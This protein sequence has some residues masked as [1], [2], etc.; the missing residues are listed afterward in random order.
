VSVAVQRSKRR[1]ARE[2]TLAQILAAA[3]A[4]LRERPFRELSVDALMAQTGHTRTVF[5]R[6]F[7][8]LADLVLRVLQAAG[9]GRLIEIAEAWAADPADD[10]ASARRALEQIVALFAEHGPLIK[11]VADAASNDEAIDAVYRGFFDR[12]VELTERAIAERIDDGR[13]APIDAHE[14]ARALTIMNARYLVE[15]FGREPKADPARAL[16]AV[17][18]IWTR[19]LYS[20][21][22]RA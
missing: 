5:Y 15:S 1:Q 14:V 4:F 11:A 3:D 20:D 10:P 22:A 7:D 6:H 9:R 18:L 2:E 8:D 17:W 21:A 19:T 13:I 12:F 16:E